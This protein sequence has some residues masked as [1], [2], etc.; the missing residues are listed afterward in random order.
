MPAGWCFIFFGQAHSCCFSRDAFSEMI[1]GNPYAGNKELL[2]LP[3]VVHTDL[4]DK[5]DVIPFEKITEF[6]HKSMR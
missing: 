5:K 1:Q 2:L 3:G 6:F 4:Y